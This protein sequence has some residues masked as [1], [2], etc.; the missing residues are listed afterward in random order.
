MDL[1]DNIDSGRATTDEMD[2]AGRSD[3]CGAGAMP[4]EAVR[5]VVAAAEV[6]GEPP[7]ITGET[8]RGPR[9]GSDG[10]DSRAG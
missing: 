5:V 4:P 10:E 9:W 8:R 6:E 7:S 2:L 3:G 1:V